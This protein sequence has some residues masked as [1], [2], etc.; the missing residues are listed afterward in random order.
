MDKKAIVIGASA[1]GS[2]TAKELAK[3]GIE[4]ELLEE[5]SQVGKF[6]KCGGIFSKHGMDFTGIRYKDLLLNEIRGARIVAG[7]EEMK[8]RT[9]QTQAVVLSRQ[10]FDERA[11]DEAVAAGAELHLNSRVRNFEINNGMGNGKGNLGT[12]GNKRNGNI[13]VKT[14]DGKPYSGKVII[15]CDGNSS[16]TA[17]NFKF[18]VIKY[19]DMVMSYQAEFLNADVPEPDIVDL[20]LDHANYRN[21]FMWTIPISDE[22]IRVGVATTEIRGIEK[23]K[24]AAFKEP[25]IAG[26]LENAKKTFEFHHMIPLRYR[27]KTQMK[28]GD[29]GYVLLVGDAAG[30][31]KATSGGG[32]NFGA[33]C[34]KIAA[35]ETANY[36]LEG[37][38]I[39]YERKWRSTHGEVLKLHYLLHR[40]YRLFPDWLTEYSLGAAKRLGMGRLLESKGDMDY[41]I[42]A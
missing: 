6:G 21:F 5:D 33:K 19:S 29:A 7:K 14:T 16:I 20:Y 36:L 17:R 37:E 26:M 2:I 41:I 34:A 22:K 42:R 8:V 10:A 4:V 38:E 32:V 3:R 27:K 11:A 40:A 23:A 1:V 12:D 24:T 25:Y 18:P 13:T 31:V 39:E 35:E 28:M 9:P 30:Q 15:G